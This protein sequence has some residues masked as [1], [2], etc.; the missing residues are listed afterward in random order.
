LT[1]RVKVCGMTRIEDVEVADEAGADAIGCIVDV[2]VHTPREVSPEIAEDILST[3]SPYVTRVVVTMGEPPTVEE[4]D[5]VQLHGDESPKD[6][7]NIV[8][9]GYRVVKTLWVDDKGVLW[10]GDDIIDEDTLNSYER[11]VD[12]FLLDTKTGVRGGSGLTHDWNASAEVVKHVNPPIILAGGLTPDNVEEAIRTVRPY[13]VDVSSGVESEPGV[14]DP[15][16]VHE[17]V[18]RAK[19]VGMERW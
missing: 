4:A 12:A 8:E 17:F 14:K 6:C 11:V 10:L 18:K 19:K 13:G 15:V 7:E 1:V 2:P 9:M 16:L 3:A 5:A